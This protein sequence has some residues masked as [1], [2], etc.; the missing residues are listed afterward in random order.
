MSP[1]KWPVYQAFKK[2][3]NKIWMY[4]ASPCMARLTELKVK[5][6][7]Q[8]GTMNSLLALLLLLRICMIGS[9]VMSDLY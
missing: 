3:G 1:G 7:S 4:P 8:N 5:L 6:G 2:A 9:H